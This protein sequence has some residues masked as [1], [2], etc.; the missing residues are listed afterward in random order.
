MRSER[1]RLAVNMMEWPLFVTLT[2][3]PTEGHELNDLKRLRQAFGKLRNQRLWKSRVRGGVAGLEVTSRSGRFHPHLHTVVDC[4]WLAIF[5]PKP[6]KGDSKAR[7]KAKCLAASQELGMEWARCLGVTSVDTA[8][9]GTIYK[10]KRCSGEHITSEILK[11]SVKGSDL[12]ETTERAGDVIRQ[13]QATRLVTSFGS[14]FG[15]ARID[16]QAEEK[17]RPCKCCGKDEWMP[18]ITLEATLRHARE[19]R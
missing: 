5:V 16:D 11:Y 13:L 2:V 12:L 18:E 14:L 6:Q 4:E 1:Y 15:K 10:V 17:P 8:W 9:S 7:I 3:P 19:Q